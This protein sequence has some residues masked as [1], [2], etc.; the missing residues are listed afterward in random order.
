MSL[1]LRSASDSGQARTPVAAWVSARPGLAL[2]CV[3]ALVWQIRI[4]LWGDV[5]WLITADERWLDGARPYRDFLEMNLPASLWLYLPAVRAARALDLR[6][7]FA[8]ALFG[9]ML[10]GAALALSAAI[11]RVEPAPGRRGALSEAAI[12]F[13]FLA[14][15]GD[16]FMERDT[17]AAVFGLPFVAA[18]AVRATGREVPRAQAL[19][20]G[21]GVGLMVCLKPPFAPIALLAALPAMFRCGPG[22]W[23]RKPEFYV[24][25]LLFGLYTLVVAAAFPDYALNV[26]PAAVAVYLPIRESAVELLGSPGALAALAFLLCG[27]YAARERLA[28][29][30]LAV[31]GFAALGAGLGYFAQGKGWLYQAYPAIAYGVVF[32]ALAME[33]GRATARALIAP[34]AVALVAFGVAALAGGWALGVVV[35]FIAGVAAQRAFRAQA[36]MRPLSA[37]LLG[38]TLALFCPRDIPDDAISRALVRLGPHPTLVGVTESFGF[39]HPRARRLGAV[40]VQSAPT[41]LIAAGAR[42]L[43]DQHP[44]DDA[45]KARLQPFIDAEKARLVEDIV[46]RRPDALLVGPLGTR[47][48][49]AIWNDPEVAAARRNYRLAARNVPPEGSGELWVREDLAARVGPGAGP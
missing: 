9:F 35:G 5:S 41:L 46:S 30:T 10:T 31:A 36:A 4:G 47:F 17:M 18:A 33:D 22:V 40:W 24:A 6:P 26:L 21:L 25:A 49:D 1:A 12:G 8:V 15:P 29:P 2:V 42:L 28:E 7:E 13:A 14:L 34:A 44:G 27:A 11:A 23:L 45:L 32:A 3:F 38:A 39:A 43:I 37:A 20:A 16:A 19:A 48:H